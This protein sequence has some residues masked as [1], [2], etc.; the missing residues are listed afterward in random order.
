MFGIGT[1]ELIFILLLALIILGPKEMQKFAR[2]L[3]RWMNAF[4]KSDTWR[5]MRKVGDEARTL[6]NRLIREAELEQL[7]NDPILREQVIRPSQ[8]AFSPSEMLENGMPRVP[9]R[10]EQPAQSASPSQ[11]PS[12]KAE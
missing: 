2:D 7:Q 3:G 1:G 9:T 5:V 8:V 12:D 10:S 11:N 6:P 4:V